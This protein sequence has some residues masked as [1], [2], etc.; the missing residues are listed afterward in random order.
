[1]IF[2]FQI[3]KSMMVGKDYKIF[4]RNRTIKS[5]LKSHQLVFPSEIIL[6][7]LMMQPLNSI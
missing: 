2:F 3:I 1:M 7:S 4:R 5:F 6:N